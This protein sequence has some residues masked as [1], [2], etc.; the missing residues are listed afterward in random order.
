MIKLNYQELIH[1]EADNMIY[2][3][4][5]DLLPTLRTGNDYVLFFSSIDINGFI[6][7]LNCIRISFI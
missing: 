2:G 4:L 7:K 1:V 6:G 5:T 3:Q